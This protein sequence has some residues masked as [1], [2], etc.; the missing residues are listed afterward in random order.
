[1]STVNPEDQPGREPNLDDVMNPEET[2]LPNADRRGHAKVP[3]GLDDEDFAAAEQEER[4][5]AGLQD[6]APGEFPP[7]TDPVP[8]GSSE[9]ADRAQ[10]GLNGEPNE[11]NQEESHG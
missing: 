3:A 7:A 9:E 10:R 8:P 2:A 4:V 5:A 1:M 6:Y 11:E